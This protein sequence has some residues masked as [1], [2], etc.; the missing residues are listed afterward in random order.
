MG[1]TRQRIG[2]N[3]KISYQ[4]LYDDASGVRQTAGTFGT[5]KESERAWQ[6][7]EA[8]IAEGRT[9]DPRRSRQKFGTY[10]M[11]T[12]LP[13][14]RI[15]LS[16][17]QDYLGALRT[18]ILP[19]FENMRMCDIS[20]QDVRSWITGLKTKE[21]GRHRIAYCKGAVL[22]AI[23]TTAVN[24]G[25]ILLH[26]SRGVPTD[27]IPEKPRRIIT[28]DEFDQIYAALPDETSRLLVETAIES[29]LRW[30]ELAELRVKDLDFGTNILTVSRVVLYLSSEIHPEGKRNLVKEYPKGRKWRKLKLSGQ[31]AAKLQAHVKAENLKRDDLF[32][33][34]RLDYKPAYEPVQDPESLGYTEPNEN[35]RVYRHGTTTA[36][37][38]GKCRCRHCRAAVA[39]YRAKRRA[40]GKDS[41]RKPRVVDLDPHMNATWFRNGTWRPACE[42]ADLGFNPRFQD[43]RHAHASW[44]LAGGADLQV[45]KER[46][47]H[48]K[49]T[50]TE[51]YLHTLP[52]AD[53]T[54]LTAL[55]KI[56]NIEVPEDATTALK[57][58]LEAA[59]AEI[60]KLRAV[61]ARQLIE[62]HFGSETGMS[63]V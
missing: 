42:A 37:G 61:I 19:Y 23:F 28:A 45:V 57:A 24:D 55:K 6:A 51:R 40:A 22:N 36:Y 43:L 50:T 20:S 17:K 54:A 30:G 8:K 48:A 2:K 41:P 3:G 16:T 14:H 38:L 10:V 58:E 11:E 44:L 7:A 25:V 4:A 15:E 56:R 18:H 49:I 9:W 60:D 47:G 46:L 12:W 32:F 59:N 31:I 26:P 53:E 63:S 1:F 21:V 35:G 27:P 33:S 5:L 13:N 34:R 52:T 29:G 39:A 62:Q